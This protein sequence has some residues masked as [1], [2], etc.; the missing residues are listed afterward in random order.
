VPS[1]NLSGFQTFHRRVEPALSGIEGFQSF[2]PFDAQTIRL[3]IP[4]NRLGLSGRIFRLTC[5]SRPLGTHLGEACSNSSSCSTRGS[6][7]KRSSRSNSSVRF[8]ARKHS[9]NARAEHA[10][11]SLGLAW[12]LR[13]WPGGL[14]RNNVTVSDPIRPNFH[15]SGIPETYTLCA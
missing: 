5:A 6:C 1:C 14:N 3:Q 8:P 11:R 15:V 10:L 7:S 4:S 2:K 9:D 13:I 12:R